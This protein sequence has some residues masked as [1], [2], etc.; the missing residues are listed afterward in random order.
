V[1]IRARSFEDLALLLFVCRIQ[2]TATRPKLFGHLDGVGRGVPGD[3]MLSLGSGG[4]LAFVNGRK[5]RQEVAEDVCGERRVRLAEV[6]ANQLG[7]VEVATGH[8]IVGVTGDDE[9]PRLRLARD[10]PVSDR[11]VA[12]GSYRPS[13]PSARGTRT[14][15]ADWASLHEA[16]EERTQR[17]LNRDLPTSGAG[18]LPRTLVR[19]WARSS[20][21]SAK[22]S[23]WRNSSC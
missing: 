21:R 1:R 19:P 16:R 22:P 4:G 5:V 14:E 7:L 15:S 10:G 23:Q 3:V 13:R 20:A 6:P 8:R 2:K 17:G 18:L 12:E 9:E 11:R